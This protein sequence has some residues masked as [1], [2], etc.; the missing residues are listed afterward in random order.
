MA[1]DGCNQLR[2]RDVYAVDRGTGRHA[3]TDDI[4]MLRTPRR[5]PTGQTVQ[6]RQ[7]RPISGSPRPRP[8][9]VFRSRQRSAT[10]SRDDDRTWTTTIGW[11]FSRAISTSNTCEARLVTTE[12]RWLHV[13]DNAAW[14]GTAT[15]GDPA[16]FAE[17]T[18]GS[19]RIAPLH[20]QHRRGRQD[21]EIHR[22]WQTVLL[23]SVRLDGSY[24][25]L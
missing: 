7:L 23:N 10:C 18:P 11:Q 21:A 20:G 6:D 16:K 15:D 1:V 22:L 8:S 25:C 24:P 9:S 13:A 17:A 2:T 19:E 4:S 14:F 12:D 5:G 3:R